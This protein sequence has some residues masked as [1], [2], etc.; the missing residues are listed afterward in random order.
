M[1][2]RKD[3]PG[4][5]RPIGQRHDTY[6]GAA[7]GGV[8]ADCK[9]VESTAPAAA[10]I[11][12]GTDV[13]DGDADVTG[14][15]RRAGHAVPAAEQGGVDALIDNTAGRNGRRPGEQGGGSASDVDRRRLD[16]RDA[17]AAGRRRAKAAVLRA[18]GRAG[19]G[20]NK[21]K[22]QRRNDSGTQ[23]TDVGRTVSKDPKTHDTPAM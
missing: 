8:H 1:L 10:G 23:P 13:A 19:T 20:N 12:G 4:L 16:Q 21:E 6:G 9:T 14:R 7:T 18:K 15:D 5:F 22:R 3:P 11:P 17:D 2:H